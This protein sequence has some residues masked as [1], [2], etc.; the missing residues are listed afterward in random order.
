MLRF[1]VWDTGRGIP[2]E[3]IDSVFREF[4]QLSNPQR[5][6][7]LG[8]GLGLAIVDRLARLLR[9]PLMVRSL[10]GKGTVFSLDVPIS[11]DDSLQEEA[12][13]EALAAMAGLQ[14]LVA[15]VDDDVMVRDSLST[16]LEAWGLQVIVAA[17]G[18]ELLEGLDRAPDILIA[19]YRLGEQDG[20]EVTQ[21]LRN[22]YPDAEF[23]VIVITACTSEQSVRILSDSGYQVMHKPVRPANLRTLIANLL[24]SAGEH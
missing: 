10:P 6:R 15:V 3:H 11:R 21:A 1:Q 4:F 23:P 2:P 13:G 5:D 16:L 22:A 14:G 19:D 18:V 24:R 20:L 12:S 7:N 8:Q 9:H 17:S